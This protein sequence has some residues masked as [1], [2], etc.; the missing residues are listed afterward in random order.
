M[1]DD[2]TGREFNETELARFMHERRTSAKRRLYCSRF[3]CSDPGGQVVS[4]P[5]RRGWLSASARR[6]RLKGSGDCRGRQAPAFS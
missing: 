5:R 3:G 2:P 4:I 6:W 1:S